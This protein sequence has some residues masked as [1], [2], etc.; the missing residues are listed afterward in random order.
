MES[1]DAANKFLTST[2]HARF[3]VEKYL[4]P[5]IGKLIEQ[6]PANI[7][8]HELNCVHE[9]LTLAVIIISRDLDIQLRRS[10]ECKLLEVF[11]LV[12]NKENASHKENQENWSNHVSGLPDLRLKMIDRFWQEQ[13]FA[14]LKTYLVER[15]GTPIFPSFDVLHHVLAALA[16]IPVSPVPVEQAVVGRDAETTAIEVAK[17]TMKFVRSCSDD[18]LTKIPLEHLNTVQHDLKRISTSWLLLGGPTHTNFTL[19]GVD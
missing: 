5:I 16:D 7:A 17:A 15:I 19:L 13:G 1:L 14:R 12:F 10:G 18:D 6:Y 3:F 9:S 4:Q 11:S 2:E 8:P